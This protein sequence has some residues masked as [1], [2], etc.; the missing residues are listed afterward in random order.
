MAKLL[1]LKGPVKGQTFDLNGEVVSIGR[2]SDNDIQIKDGTVSRKHLK[3]F[4]IGRMFF[5]EDLKSTN[6]TMI[7]GEFIVPGEGFEVGGEDSICIGKTVLRLGGIPQYESDLNQDL[8]SPSSR[9][10]QSGRGGFSPE[11]RSGLSTSLRLMKKISELLAQALDIQEIFQ[12]VLKYLL[13]CLPRIDRAAILLFDKRNGKIKDVIVRSRQEQ[14]GGEVHYSQSVADRVLQSGKA[15]SMSDTTGNA[16]DFS[17]D[18][19]TLKIRS[20]L[21]VPLVCNGEIRG[22]IYIDSLR[23]AHG[24]RDEDLLLITSVSG[25]LALALENARLA[26]RMERLQVP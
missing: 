9:E 12:E 18:M 15:V 6:G 4:R 1:V 24:F 10:G 11:R 7:N 25:P 8:G 2:T 3:V 22:A 5:V 19:D 21:C 20:V 14:R 26:A 17:E 23:G 16:A 13:E